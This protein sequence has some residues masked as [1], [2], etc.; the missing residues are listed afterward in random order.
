M[1]R[2]RQT[3]QTL[4]SEAAAA[5]PDSSEATSNQVEVQQTGM[6]R[7]AMKFMPGKISSDKYEQRVGNCTKD[8]LS[9][10]MTSPDYQEWQQSRQVAKPRQ[11]TIPPEALLG[12]L[13][14]VV[15]PLVA[16]APYYLPSYDQAVSKSKIPCCATPVH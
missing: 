6:Q 15:L 2:T 5:A 8:Q 12:L 4:N 7:S 13:C 10:L 14:L 9:L 1:A 11:W 3:S 16:L